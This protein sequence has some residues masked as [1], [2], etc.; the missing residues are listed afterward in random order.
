MR[1]P[2]LDPPDAVVV[3]AIAEHLIECHDDP[4]E[5]VAEA[6]GLPVKEFLDQYL[7]TALN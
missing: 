3:E 5:M 2:P 6:L 7:P 1:L 4:V